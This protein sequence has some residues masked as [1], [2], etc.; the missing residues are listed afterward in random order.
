MQCDSSGA[1][2]SCAL[3]GRS[4]A[5]RPDHDYNE[6]EVVRL[7]AENADL[8]EQLEKVLADLDRAQVRPPCSTTCGPLRCC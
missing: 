2:L 7:R 6:V 8:R 1:P 5:E 4:A 3:D